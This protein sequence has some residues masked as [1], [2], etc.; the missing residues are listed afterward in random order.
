MNIGLIYRILV[1]PLKLLVFVSSFIIPRRNDLVVCTAGPEGRFAENPKYVYLDL[2]EDNAYDPIWLSRD[3]RTAAQLRE[4]DLPTETTGT[5]AGWL[6]LLRAGTVVVS[7][8]YHWPF[9]GGATIIQTHHGNPL[10]KTGLDIFE[11]RRMFWDLESFFIR[12]WDVF[13]VTGSKAPKEKFLSAY[14]GL[15]DNIAVTGYPRTDVFYRDIPFS[16]LDGTT[17][18]ASWQSFFSDN[19]CILY[20]P[21]W[22]RGIYG[23]DG[24]S[25]DEHGLNF[26]EIRDFCEEYDVAFVL[27]LHP[28]ESINV[29]SIENVHLLPS[30]VDVYDLLSD[31]EILVTDYSSVYFDFLLVDNPVVFYPYDLE[32]YRETRGLY[33]SYNE[34]T[35]GPSAQ[36]TTELLSNL[37]S[38]LEGKTDY[39]EERAEIKDRFYDHDDGRSSYRVRTIINEYT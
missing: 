18:H 14:D 32:S 12:N 7:H 3:S 38:V 20:M 37:G 5:L 33:F 21:T 26:E 16:H 19:R 9:L 25:F 2:L 8:D 1:L 22:R 11:G 15:D 39:K 27:K 36:S 4:H 24:E 31:T 28:S 10:K 34:V 29:E 6:V 13:T 30:D 17:E 23:A 35:P